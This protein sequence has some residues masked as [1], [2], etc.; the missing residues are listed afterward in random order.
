MPSARIGS[1]VVVTSSRETEE[2]KE[3]NKRLY[4]ANEAAAANPKHAGY[5]FFKDADTK[6]WSAKRDASGNV[7]IKGKAHLDD[8]RYRGDLGPPEIAGT[9]ATLSLTM[10]ENRSYAAPDNWWDV[11]ATIPNSAAIT[12]VTVDCGAKTLADLKVPAKD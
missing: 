6:G 2:H 11:T 4:A 8:S 12:S 10:G 1:G 9:A 3:T 7:K 5:C